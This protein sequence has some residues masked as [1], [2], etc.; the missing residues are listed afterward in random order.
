VVTYILGR[1]LVI[2]TNP[3]KPKLTITKQREVA[4][5]QIL[6]A[7]A[8][9]T[10]N[11]IRN[12]RAD[13]LAMYGQLYV[14]IFDI[15]INVGLRG[16]DLLGIMF[17][18]VNYKERELRVVEQKTGKLRVIRLNDKVLSVI[19]RRHTENPDSLYLFKST[20]NRAKNSNK[21]LSLSSLNKVLADVGKQ[22]NLK[23]SSHS[24]R[25]SFG[26]GLYRHGKS[27]ELISHILNHRSPAETLKYIGITKDEVMQSYD[28]VIL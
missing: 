22:F 8:I 5:M 12:I 28:D 17:S 11:L 19:K 4:N 1:L 20:H 15:G 24:L 13:I 2:E 14:D 26:A 10:A 6:G 21:P 9:K 3:Y 25:K 23:L 7:D 16:G 18:A 27:I